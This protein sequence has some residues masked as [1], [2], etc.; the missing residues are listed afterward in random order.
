MRK[1]WKQALRPYT[2]TFHKLDNEKE[3]SQDKT[4]I[5]IKNNINFYEKTYITQLLLMKD[6]LSFIL[7]TAFIG[8]AFDT[9]SQSDSNAAYY[10]WATWLGYSAFVLSSGGIG[11]VAAGIRDARYQCDAWSELEELSNLTPSDPENPDSSG[12]SQKQLENRRLLLL[13]KIN[14]FGLYSHRGHWYGKRIVFASLF[15]LNAAILLLMQGK[16]GKVTEGN[17]LSIILVVIAI[18]S[19]LIL[20]V[21]V[22]PFRAEPSCYRLPQDLRK[23]CKN[24]IDGDDPFKVTMDR[25]L[26]L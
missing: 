5:W 1:S 2:I 4:K 23:K 13:E 21:V 22:S 11:V 9:N 25:K 3:W 12:Y 18:W 17:P 15:C 24:Y 26:F 6:I 14:L 16:I 10:K 20:S 8:L 7:A 19:T